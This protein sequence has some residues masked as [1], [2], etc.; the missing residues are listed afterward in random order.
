[1]LVLLGFPIEE[2]SIPGRRP[3]WLTW[4]TA[5]ALLVAW[6]AAL[7]DPAAVARTFG[8][9]S[10]QP[11]RA[12]GLTLVSSFFVH[13]GFLHLAGNA[14][15]PLLAGDD[16]EDRLGRE[17][18]LALLLA[19][20]LAGHLVHGAIDPRADVPCVGAS[21]GISGLLACY[22]VLW[23]HQ[24]L[25]IRSPRRYSSWTSSS[26]AGLPRTDGSR[27]VPLR[28]LARRPRPPRLPPVVRRDPRLRPRPPRRRGGRGR[29]GD[30]DAPRHAMTR[31]R[32]YSPSPGCWRRLGR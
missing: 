17:R 3:T 16:L 31:A 18:W 2:T 10:A 24:R 13:A 32:R 22:A 15:F 19:A 8:F 26:T 12:G 28:A 6:L 23:P 7:A 4:G 14:W 1:M 21:G 27:L 5:A 29:D 11:F 25:V 20:T 9:V 30:R